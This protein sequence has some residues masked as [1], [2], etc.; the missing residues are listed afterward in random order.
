MVH[1]SGYLLYPGLG[2][3]Y[4]RQM[5]SNFSDFLQHVVVVA[6]PTAFDSHIE[7]CNA[8]LAKALLWGGSSVPLAASLLPH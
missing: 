7:V 3:P 5:A 1:L 4:S 6:R 8:L 2:S